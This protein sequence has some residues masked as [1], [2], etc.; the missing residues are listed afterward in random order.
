MIASSIYSSHSSKLGP[1]SIVTQLPSWR[2]SM[3]KQ[4]LVVFVSATVIFVAL[5]LPLA[6]NAQAQTAI[7]NV[8]SN[9]QSIDGFGFSTAWC[10]AITSAQGSVLF[11]TGAGQLGFSL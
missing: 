7:I 5:A 10:P 3:K 8:G 9:L 6:T 2:L 4:H 1:L 11:G